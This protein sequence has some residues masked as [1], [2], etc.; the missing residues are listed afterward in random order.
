MR[1]LV[2]GA[3]GKLGRAVVRDLVAHGYEVRGA[4]RDVPARDDWP[5]GARYVQTDLLDVGQ[6]AYPMQGCEAVIHLG[7]IPAPY[8]LPDEVLFRNN[9]GATFATLQAASLL[10]V[11]RAAIA[12][13]GSAYGM[14]WAPQP[15]FP[16]YAPID[17][18]HP[19]MNHDVYGVGK[20][21]DERVA[22][23]FC[24][25]DGMS[26]AALRFHWIATPEEQRHAAAGMEQHPEQGANGLWGYVDLR[27]AARACRLAIEAAPFG[28]A[29]LNIVAADTLTAQP[30]EE[31]I[32]QHSPGTEL[33]QPLPG[34][35]GGFAIDRAKA[36]I[37]WAPEHSWRDTE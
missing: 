29:P 2:T 4:D 9:T 5:K 37:G 10:G 16:Q 25:R 3:N 12:S 6:V 31:A 32:R 27:D 1:V 11:K 19:M 18:A 33:R 36:V 23:M 13:S 35:T 8:G 20:E 34:H 14:A 30:T 21:V 7:A 15:L 24:R 22:E 17:E 28:F 26:I